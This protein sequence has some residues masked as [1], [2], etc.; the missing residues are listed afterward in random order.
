M[1]EEQSRDSAAEAT[2]SGEDIEAKRPD[3]QPE[4]D[5]DEEYYSGTEGNHESEAEEQ[6]QEEEEE[7]E[8]EGPSNQDEHTA[9]DVKGTGAQ[10]K[11]E[12]EGGD[13]DA[14][15]TDEPA[16]EPTAAAS[17]SSGIDMNNALAKA[18]A[19]AAKLG[20][21]QK[22]Q[23]SAPRAVEDDKEG[24]AGSADQDEPLRDADQGQ[25]R[26][27]NRRSASPESR[28]NRGPRGGKRERSRSRDRG[29][30][31]H[32]PRRD[33]RRRFDGPEGNS[34]NAQ[35]MHHQEQ[36]A[37]EL[38][39]PSDLAGLIIGRSGSNLRS[40]EQRHG[41]RVQFDSNYD[42]RAPERRVTIEG[43][44]QQAEGAKQDIMD[45]I[46]RHHR[47]Q[48]QPFRPP[49]GPMD[50]MSPMDAPPQGL[51]GPMDQAAGMAVI[52]VPN[53]KVGLIIGRRG[54][55]IKSIQMLSGARVQVQPDDGRGAPE[56]PIHLIG[57][58]DQI[59]AARIRIMEIVS[60]DKPPSRDPGGPS[61]GGYGR[62]DYAPG[63]GYSSMPQA[64]G[65]PP[66][67]VGGYGSPRMPSSGGYG[68][69]QDRYGG[70]P[71]PMQMG[72]HM[73]ELQIPVEAVGIIIGRS[74]ETIKHLQQSSGTRIQILQGPE[75]SGPYRTVTV[76]G[77]PNACMRGRRM[78][79][80]K[81]EGLQ[82]RMSGGP[83]Q[84][85]PAAGGGYGGGAGPRSGMYGGGYGQQH[86]SQQQ[87]GSGYGGGYGY[88]AEPMDVAPGSDQKPQQWAQQPQQ[89]QQQQPYYGGPSGNNAAAYG[90][91]YQ[92]PQQQQQQ[93][94]AGG[95]QT[96]QWTNKQT[97][98]YY[99]QYAA[100]NPEY[101]QY[102]DYYRK[103]AETDPNGI[104]P[105]G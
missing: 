98:D 104:V 89:P 50:G 74:G 88:G 6:V 3:E 63:G 4:N 9:S 43:S 8:E 53:S 27:Q 103:L 85:A 87:P 47:M 99:A 1:S 30:Q 51:G 40:I 49:A 36:G 46:D 34:Y 58:P 68:G 62:H 11:E 76:S 29:S 41:V 15:G 97:A 71:P 73:E 75:H 78:I 52:T 12:A 105:S 45:F 5:E 69:P 25:H 59:E 35:P 96:M 84:T 80:E 91:G 22:P 2:H 44:A 65:Q 101:A 95:D 83:P 64:H 23:A 32:E 72:G 79:E 17:T 57:S 77:D 20:S 102:A 10:E 60:T 92:Q 33:A 86:H 13:S 14:S 39:V 7:E 82:D 18:R 56:R 81:I 94:Q 19:I 31:R 24:G 16:P 70:G 42:K 55:S 66:H 54:E 48:D 61:D 37:I 38:H 93:Q 26:Q 21:M 28:A 67:Q 90:G 100:T